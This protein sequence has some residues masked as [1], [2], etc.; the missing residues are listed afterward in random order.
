MAK[1]LPAMYET[2]VQSL[3]MNCVALGKLVNLVGHKCYAEEEISNY[4]EGQFWK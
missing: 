1:Y 3:G 4:S 2:Q